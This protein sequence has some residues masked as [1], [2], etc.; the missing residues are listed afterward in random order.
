MTIVTC[1]GI[2]LRSHP[3]S[4]SSRILRFLTPDL[5]IVA[6]IARG[7]RRKGGGGGGT[8][9]TFAEGTITFHHRPDRDLHTLRDFERG[10][11]SM[12]L[13]RDL[14]R[15]MGASLLAELILA[16]ALEEEGPELYAR[17]RESLAGMA[18]IPVP[19][20]PGWILASCWSTLGLLGFLPELDQCVRCGTSFADQGGAAAA[21]ADE[22]LAGF[23]AAAG[24][25]RCAECAVGAGL[26]RLGPVARG[27][28]RCLVSGEA[29]FPLPGARAHL[30]LLEAF[31]LHHL[32]PARGFRSFALLGELV[33]S[34]EA[35]GGGP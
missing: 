12:A 29:P 1:P 10:T 3:Y 2:L 26:P 11:G 28:L 7:V 5:G 25:V 8:P 27:H 19:E 13:G 17:F 32:A 23:D 9:E 6:L 20:L 4:E 21:G 31:A 33:K 16:H 15:F 18:T 34:G 24:G 30:G 14:Q 35:G 22:P